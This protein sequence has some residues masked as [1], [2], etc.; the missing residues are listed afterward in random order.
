[1]LIDESRKRRRKAGLTLVEVMLAIMIL[2]IGL[3]A[4]IAA[5]SRC[6]SVVRQS[7]TYETTRN[8]LTRVD[9][10]E[11]LQ[12]KEEIREESE[13]G[14]F[15]EFPGYRW[16]REI[17]SVGNEE[18]GLYEVTTRVYWSERGRESFD[19]VVTYLYAPE[20]TEGG[21]VVSR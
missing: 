10:E 21:T 6:L 3:T 16:T 11:P 9:L 5:A 7:K 12:L 13:T 19:E 4:L 18:D 2:A 8:L 1:M 17:K 15:Q 20:E 14:S